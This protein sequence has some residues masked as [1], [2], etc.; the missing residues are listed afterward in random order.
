MSAIS[1]RVLMGLL[2]VLCV[3]VAV[4]F[5]QPWVSVEMKAVSALNHLFGNK[6]RTE[7]TV[8]SGYDIPRMA[9]TQ[10]SRLLINI[11][12]Q[13]NADAKDADKK[14]Y[15]VW[16]VPA[17]PFVLLGA[18][19]LARRR[20]AW[21]AA[22]ALIFLGAFGGAL[23]GIFTTELDGLATAVHIKPGLWVLLYAYLAAGLANLTW[24]FLPAPATQVAGSEFPPD[25]A[26]TGGNAR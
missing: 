25:A 20:R 15:L 23:Y 8:I 5:F 9:N 10:S 1:H 14:S 24:C 13:F 21:A 7:M 18:T 2:C 16:L 6:G 3:V 19:W 4:C 12:Q 17:L 26:N 11:V 22:P